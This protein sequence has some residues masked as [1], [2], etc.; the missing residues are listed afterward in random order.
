M[1]KKWGISCSCWWWLGERVCLVRY[2]QFG[3]SACCLSVSQ[4]RPVSPPSDFSLTPH[5]QQRQRLFNHPETVASHGQGLSLLPLSYNAVSQ[6]KPQAE[7]MEIIEEKPNDPHNPPMETEE[8]VS[9]LDRESCLACPRHTLCI[10]LIFSPVFQMKLSPPNTC[11]I[12]AMT[13]KNS[14]SFIGSSRA[15]RNSRRN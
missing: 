4:L 3:E 12:W 10:P 14:R 2:A 9:V 5:A 8:I 13:L 6:P 1:R 15:G 11:L 7:G